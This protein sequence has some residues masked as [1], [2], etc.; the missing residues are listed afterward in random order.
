M[1]SPELS[2][3]GRGYNVDF[4]GDEIK[5]NL[6]YLDLGALLKYS[7]SGQRQHRHLRAAGP[8]PATPSAVKWMTRKIEFDD[9]DGFNRFNLQIGRGRPVLTFAEMFFAEVRY[10]AGLSDLNS[11]DDID[12]SSKW[13]SIGINGGIRIP[14]G[15]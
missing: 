14:L 3:V 12:L 6:S 10:Q 8:V 9:N 1:I 7:V 13:K 2:Y 4:G 5:T 11:D 15:N